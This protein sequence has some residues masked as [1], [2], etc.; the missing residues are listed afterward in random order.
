MT[1]ET[2]I[3]LK[4][5]VCQQEVQHKPKAGWQT[6]EIRGEKPAAVKSLPAAKQSW[7][8]RSDTETRHPAPAVPQTSFLQG[9]ASKASTH[10]E[11]YL[12]STACK[13][14]K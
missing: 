12:L 1:E 5:T 10:Q 9:S 2:F 4:D 6:N 7:S 11:D 3:A 8:Y 14:K 13:D